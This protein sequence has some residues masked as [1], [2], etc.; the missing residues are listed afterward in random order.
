MME[1]FP[2]LSMEGTA[3]FEQRKVPLRFVFMIESQ[4]STLSS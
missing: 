3:Y 1:P 2:S 4:V